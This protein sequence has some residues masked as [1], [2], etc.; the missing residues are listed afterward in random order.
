MKH[1][2]AVFFIGLLSFSVNA[3][4]KVAKIDFKAD[5]IDYGIIEKGADGVRVFEFT[6]TG[7]APLIISK[8]NS[9]C[10]CTVPKKPEGPIQPGETGQIEVKYDTNRVNPIR[11]T[12]TVIS[13]ADTP[14][15]A[16]KIK[17]EVIDPSKTSVLE[18]KNQSVM[19]Q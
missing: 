19:E 5:V 7:N 10:G 1:L 12:I 4:E 17:G 15:V 8:V 16:L 6:N 13:N 18:K 2:L 14:T 3:Q 11:K 9:S